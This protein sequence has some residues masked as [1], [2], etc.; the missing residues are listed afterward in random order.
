MNVIWITADTFRRDHLGCYG[1]PT[2]HTPSLD[3]LAARSTRFNRHYIANFPTMPTRADFLTGRWTACFMAWQ[4][5]PE[6][7]ITLPYLLKDD[8]HTAGIVDTPFFSPSEFDPQSKVMNY[9]RDFRTFINVD[10]QMPPIYGEGGR[11]SWRLESDRLPSQTF[12]TAMEWLEQHYKEDFFLYIDTFDPHEPWDAPGYYTELYWPDYDGEWIE[13]VYGSWKKIPG[14]TEEKVK[15]AHATY[16]GEVTMVDTWIGRLLKQ[17]EYMGLMDNTAIIFTADHGFYF[18]EH[19]G[20]F[21]KLARHKPTPNPFWVDPPENQVWGRSPL[22]E[23]VAGSPLLI[24]MPG[25]EPGVSQGL[26]SAVDIMPTVLD[27]L[28]QPIPDVVEG[29]SLLPMIKDPELK[30]RD[31]VISTMQFIT[32]DV[33]V[34]TEE[35]SLFF[36]D[37]PGESWLYH[38]PSDPG[39][40]KNVIKQNPEVAREL[41]RLLV[42]F[43]GDYKLAP[44]LRA[45]FLELRL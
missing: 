31:F 41:H 44:N 14:Y 43:T 12:T 2:I 25:A 9:D 38:L 33:T 29:Q 18:G 40:E 28:G 1:N 26:T 27:I 6:G 16:C 13:P 39:Q 3:A 11:A 8:F 24:Y 32:P 45:P 42:K 30:G 15:K 35:W 22:F 20:L 5:I 34:T 23:E 17:V 36:S 21:G 19:D 37:E 7:V 10:G 4:P